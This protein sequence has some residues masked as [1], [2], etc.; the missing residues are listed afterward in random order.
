MVVQ[1]DGTLKPVTGDVFRK[2]PRSERSDT[3][4]NWDRVFWACRKKNMTFRQ[5]EGWFVHQYKYYPKRTL[6]FM[7]QNAGDWLARMQDVPFS[8]LIGYDKSKARVET[9]TPERMLFQ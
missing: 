5:A 3:Q 8:D 2:I 9:K 4:K 1:L 6:N 7:P